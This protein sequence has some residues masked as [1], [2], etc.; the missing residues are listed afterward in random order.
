MNKI[1]WA[2]LTYFVG[3]F[4]ALLA[5]SYLEQEPSPARPHQSDVHECDNRHSSLTFL[6]AHWALQGLA[7]IGS[8]VTPSAVLNNPLN[9]LPGF[10]IFSRAQVFLSSNTTPVILFKATVC[11][12]SQCVIDYQ[13]RP[14]GGRY[15][16][17]YYYR[18]T[19][20]AS[21]TRGRLSSRVSTCTAQ[22]APL[23]S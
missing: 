8:H 12:G 10:L 14:V 20:Y 21:I 3:Y 11:K 17:E 2:C 22:E 1:L 9:W 6:T 15:N 4:S 5:S 13:Y 18:Q 23:P 16:V 19:M 7:S